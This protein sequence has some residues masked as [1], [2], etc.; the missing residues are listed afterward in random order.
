ML[1]WADGSHLP[2]WLLI[3][4]LDRLMTGDMSVSTTLWVSFRTDVAFLSLF[5]T[6]ITTYGSI[7][8]ALGCFPFALRSP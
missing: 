8:Y 3:D 1:V 7:L 2:T 6:N 4:G 5:L